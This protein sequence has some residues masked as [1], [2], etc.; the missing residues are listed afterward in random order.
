MAVSA[1]KEN[2]NLSLKEVGGIQV[3]HNNRDVL[4]CSPL[5]ATFISTALEGLERYKPSD[6]ELAESFILICFENV[7]DELAIQEAISCLESH[8]PLSKRF[9]NDCFKVFLKAAKNQHKPAI[10]RA[11][12][13]K[14]AFRLAIDSKA[15]RYQLISYLIELPT[16]DEFNYLRHAAKIIGLAHTF[17]AEED[18]ILVLEKLSEQK[19]GADE[20]LFELG[21]ASLSVALDAPSADIARAEF[22]KAQLLFEKAASAREVRLDAEVFDASISTLLS[23]EKDEPHKSYQQNLQRLKQ[24]ITL[25]EAWNGHEQEEIWTK[26]KKTEM[27]NWYALAIKLDALSN[28][29]AEPSWLEPIIVIEQSLLEIYKASRTILKRDSNGALEILLQPKIEASLIQNQGQLYVLEKW[30][31]RSSKTKLNSVGKKLIE[32]VKLCKEDNSL[33]KQPGTVASTRNTVPMSDLIADLPKAEKSA[34]SQLWEDCTSLQQKGVSPVLERIL[35][36]I[37]SLASRI[38][39]YEAPRVKESFNLL[40]LHTLRFL[41]SRMDMTKKNNP[42]VG[43]LLKGKEEDSLPKERKLQEDYHDYMFGNIVCGDIKSEVSDVSSGRVDVYFSFGAIHFTAEVKRDQKDCSFEALRK[44]YLGQAAEYQNTNVKLGFLL[45]LDLT[46]K[47]H[48]GNSIE[49][50]INVEI[51]TSPNG[52]TERLVVVVRVPGNRKVPSKTVINS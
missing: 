11:W 41:E 15:L 50:N 8:R 25:H 3:L 14:E 21:I 44:K 10:T 7:T 4:S 30:L 17:W 49:D 48:G 1:L 34:I 20:A 35:E 52:F 40:L 51:L 12:S 18:L 42:R 28:H 23:F 38:K 16:E 6:T 32:R 2:R 33:G 36:R 13:L 19:S 43:Y 27:A 29:L 24:A 26:A 9:T 37:L 45:V 31:K 22:K 39:D 5:I 47:S 46:E